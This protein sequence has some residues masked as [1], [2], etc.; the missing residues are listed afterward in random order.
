MQHT[1]AKRKFEQR[2]NRLRDPTGRHHR[3]HHLEATTIDAN[4]E[5]DLLRP[6]A[7]FYRT[8]IALLQS[9]I[10]DEYVPDSDSG[11]ATFPRRRQRLTTTTAKG[12]S[13][14]GKRHNKTHT[15]CRRCGQYNHPETA[16]RRTQERARAKD[17]ILMRQPYR[18]PF[19]PRSEAHLRLLR[20]PRC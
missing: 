13:S 19:P 1:L 8:D 9:L 18:S 17:E 7:S 5:P 16:R 20:L 12:T 14:F 11:R 10:Q 6:T 2:P 4:G 15:L 3:R